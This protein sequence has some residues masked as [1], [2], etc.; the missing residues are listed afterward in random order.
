MCVDLALVPHH[1]IGSPV[2][3]VISEIYLST[4]R[5]LPLLGSGLSWQTLVYSRHQS[6]GPLRPSF[7]EPGLTLRQL[8]LCRLGQAAAVPSE[9]DVAAAKAVASVPY[10]AP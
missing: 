9:P 5:Q 2:M 3:A 10:S 4:S 6:L 7:G 1:F 8:G